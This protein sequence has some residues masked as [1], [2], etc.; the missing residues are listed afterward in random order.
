MA[1]IAPAFNST[2]EAGT[3]YKNFLARIQPTTKPAIAA[4]QALGLYTKENGSAFFDA[5]GKYVGNR[6]AAELLKNATKDLT[7]EQRAQMLQ[8]IFGNDAMGAAVKLSMDGAAGYDAMASKIDKATGV[9]GAAATMQD[10]Y[11]TALKNFGGSI[12]TLQIT[13]GSAFLPVLTDLFNNVLSPAV[14][15]FTDLTAALSGD[16]DAFNKLSPTMQ[17]IASGLQVIVGV[18]QDLTGEGGGIVVFAD[19]IREMTGIDITPLTTA[20]GSL[21]DVWTNTL[22]PAIQTVGDYF[23]TNIKPVLDNLATALFPLLGAAIQV[24]SG[25]WTDVLQPALKT[26]WDAFN[27]L[28]LPV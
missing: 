27:T 5:T 9:Q 12:E 7:A 16:D 20:T 13:I 6:E 15:T 1:E 19:D 28:I 25:F 11:N 23:T 21:S 18:V 10:G 17:S 4:M 24:L 14:N 3:G 22:Q 8:T 26:A 2:T